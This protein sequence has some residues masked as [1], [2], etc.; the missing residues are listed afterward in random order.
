SHLVGCDGGEEGVA[1]AR[2]SGLGARGVGDPG[3]GGSGLGARGSS[4]HTR[5][6]RSVEPWYRR[7]GT[8]TRSAGREAIDN[9]TGRERAGGRKPHDLILI[10]R[11]RRRRR[12][13]VTERISEQRVDGAARCG[14]EGRP[15]AWRR[16]GL[17][18]ADVNQNNGG[19]S[20]KPAVT[21]STGAEGPG[22]PEPPAGADDPEGAGHAPTWS[23]SSPRCSGPGGQHLQRT[24]PPSQTSCR[25]SRQHSARFRVRAMASASSSAQAAFGLG[26]KK[27]NPTLM[28]QIGTFFGGDKKRKSKLRMNAALSCSD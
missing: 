5:G 7:G 3:L 22:D 1:R 8:R 21:D 10:P 23:A 19:V 18:E 27:K 6:E 25:P 16:G 17:G 26:R 11:T 24:A 15:A 2:G 4:Q 9:L 28:D 14:R 12:D 20:E 13:N